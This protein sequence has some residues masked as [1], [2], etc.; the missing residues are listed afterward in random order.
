VLKAESRSS[1]KLVQSS[2]FNE[3]LDSLTALCAQ[4]KNKRFFERLAL[5]AFQK[6]SWGSLDRQL[7]EMQCGALSAALHF[8]IREA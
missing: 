6:I 8:S 2:N 7:L 1:L 3:L 4:S 5:Q